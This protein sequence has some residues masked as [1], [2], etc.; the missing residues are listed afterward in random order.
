[1]TRLTCYSFSTPRQHDLYRSFLGSTDHQ[2]DVRHQYAPRE[3][4]DLPHAWHLK[5]QF[6]LGIVDNLSPD[7]T[8]VYADNDV[9][10]LQPA[11]ERLLELL[12]DRTAV[13]QDD[14]LG[15]INSGLFIARNTSSFREFW[16]RVTSANRYYAT[17]D[18][19][20]DQAA[21]N[22]HRSMID[23]HLLPRHEFY[24][25]C[26]E[27]K[28]YARHGWRP[29]RIPKGCLAYHACCVFMHDKGPVLEAVRELADLPRTAISS[30]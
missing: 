12:G 20:G 5:A 10:F 28:G 13:F 26:V 8:F 18:S 3:A 14:G 11:Q 6:I 24:S 25:P 16:G 21:A 30:V 7:A 23:H 15:R 22:R 29:S 19:G 4:R 2:F 27:L 1:M 9:L 17:S